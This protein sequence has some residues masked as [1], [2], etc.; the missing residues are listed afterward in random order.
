M[1]LGIN[2]MGYGLVNWL[3]IFDVSP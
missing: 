3:E 1:G 2:F